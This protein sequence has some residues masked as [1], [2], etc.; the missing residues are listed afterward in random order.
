MT[1]QWGDTGKIAYGPLKTFNITMATPLE[2]VYGTPINL[3]TTA[4]TSGDGVVQITVQQSNLPT[5]SSSSYSTQYL[6]HLIVAGKNNSGASGTVNFSIYKN[7]VAVATN[8][9]QASIANANYWTQTHYRWAGISVGDVLEVRLWGSATGFILEYYGL[10]V[11]P[12]KPELT[13]S[14]IIKDFSFTGASPSLTA[15]GLT[16]AVSITQGWNFY[17]TSLTGSAISTA[18]NFS[19]VAANATNSAVHFFGRPFYDSAGTFT[20]THV[21]NRPNYARCFSPTS[22]SFREI[23]R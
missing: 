2:N 23:L 11:Y 12:Y 5:I 13:K 19:M 14:A 20:A 6:A 8:Q 9:I 4:P 15:S 1:I 7:G 10:I 17:P 22:I 18:A 21:S 16:S 3:P